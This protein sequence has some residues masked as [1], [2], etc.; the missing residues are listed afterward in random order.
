MQFINA[1]IASALTLFATIHGSI[2]PQSPVVQNVD[3]EYAVS[4]IRV[5]STAWKDNF[6]SGQITND[7][8]R[9]VRDVVIK[10]SVSKNRE[11]WDVES[12]H[13]IVIKKTIVGG[14]TLSFREKIINSQ[15][16]PW[17]TTQVMSVDEYPFS[18]DLEE[19][20]VDISTQ[21]LSSTIQQKPKTEVATDLNN[22]TT[23]VSCIGPDGKEFNTTMDDCKN[24]NEKWGKQL[25][26]MVNCDLTSCGNGV[27]RMSKSQCDRPCGGLSNKLNSSSYTPNNSITYST[28]TYSCT[29]YDPILKTSQ[30]YLYL[31]KSKEECDA[32]QQKM[33][34]SG[35]SYVPPAAMPSVAI[36]TKNSAQ[37]CYGQY[38]MDIQA[39]G[40]W[41]GNVGSAMTDMANRYLERCLK[42][43]SVTVVGPV[44]P[45]TRPRDRG[46]KLCSEYGPELKSYSQ[47][48]GCP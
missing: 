36:T 28:T 45:D 42:T 8:D 37:A 9:S 3:Y 17:Y 41:G 35:S 12:E 30:T 24:L 2:V 16:D 47:S 18:I 32:E 39:A 10:V 33:N 25:N 5:E 21:D 38:K 26:Y 40:T 43:G 46:G 4:K 23:Q 15:V 31:Y 19:T 22:A 29:L 7:N 1:I 6:F 14:Q 48:M 34:S 27:L 13:P 44:Q 11:L 20:G